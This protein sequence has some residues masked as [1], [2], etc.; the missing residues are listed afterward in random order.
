MSY[1]TDETYD[2]YNEV[3]PIARRQ[4]TCSACK[5]AIEVGHRYTRVSIV[6]DGEASTV[7][8][9]ARCQ[10]MHEH[11]RK[12]SP[13]EM[14]PEEKLDCGLAYLDEWGEDPPEHI[15]ALA[16]WRPG[17]PLPTKSEANDDH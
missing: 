15:A 16:F 7:K 9:C 3:H 13:G 10:A 14:W 6:I 12:L 8:R 5:E 11:L 4:H 2:V 1:Q 17:D